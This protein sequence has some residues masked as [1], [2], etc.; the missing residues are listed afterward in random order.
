M[1]I[2]EMIEILTENKKMGE[3]KGDERLVIVDNWGKKCIFDFGVTW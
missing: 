3:C 1:T 2:D